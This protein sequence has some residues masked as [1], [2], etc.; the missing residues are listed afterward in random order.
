MTKSS[1]GISGSGVALLAGGSILL[2]SALKGRKW[3]EVF[4]E[5]VTGKQPTTNNDY[6]I[7]E[8]SGGT[9]E[10][11]GALGGGTVGSDTAHA[12]S[13]TGLLT[14]SGRPMSGDTIASPYLPLG[15]KI[16]VTY[17]GKTVSGTVWDFGPADWVLAKDPTRFLDLS[18]TMMKTLTGKSSDLIT[19]QYTVT[20]YGTGRIYRPGS[21]MTAQLKNRWGRT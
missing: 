1:G 17:N 16:N 20:K 4:R 3:S 18:T 6:P 12:S 10:V 11:G 7:T 5:L 19:V 21:A 8:T 15:T 9:G 13:F 2:W 14:A